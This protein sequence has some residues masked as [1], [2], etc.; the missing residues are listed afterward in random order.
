VEV[1]TGAGETLRFRR[2]R[3]DK[4]T[5]GLLPF[6]DPVSLF[7]GS[8]GTLGVVTRVWLRL[9]GNPG[10]Y[11][12]FVL[13][14]RALLD[15]LRAAVALRTRQ[16]SVHPRCVE[17]FDAGALK[18]LATHARAPK[19][20]AA[21]GAALY[22]EL[23]RAEAEDVERLVARDLAQLLPFGLLLDD[24]IVGETAAE[25][26][27]IRDLRHHI[28]E[29]CNRAAS[30]HHAT[31]GLKVSADFA[32]PPDRLLEMMAVVEESRVQHGVDVMVRYGHVGNGH[33]HVFMRGRNPDE[34]VR[35]RAIVLEWSDRVVAMGGTVAAEHGIGK[36]R[37]YLLPRQYPAAVL[38]A[39]NAVKRTFD[40]HGLMARGNIFEPAP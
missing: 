17:L 18:M 1:V 40:P 21:A 12:A 31:G 9:C 30:E 33:P 39:M 26:A 16:V 8:E 11:V 35:L 22:V 25:K 36:T 13:P 32:V 37:R 3:V 19:L 2:S 29:T 23:D 15:A 34:V 4:N 5:A 28:P 14:F 20:P 10:P 24:T 38:A 6:H 27:W 7:V